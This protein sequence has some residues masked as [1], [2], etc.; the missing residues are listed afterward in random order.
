[1][2]GIKPGYINKHQVE[3]ALLRNAEDRLHLKS[4]GA[5]EELFNNDRSKF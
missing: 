5:T 1:M 4:R 3:E 2:L